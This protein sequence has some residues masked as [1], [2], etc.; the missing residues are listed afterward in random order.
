MISRNNKAQAS[1]PMAGRM[2]QCASGECIHTEHEGRWDMV[3]RESDVPTS[4]GG[5]EYDKCVNCD[6]PLG[7]DGKCF[8][9]DVP[10]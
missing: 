1:C 3:E 2:A 5:F 7:T 4:G 6:Q 9:C 8:Q 10:V